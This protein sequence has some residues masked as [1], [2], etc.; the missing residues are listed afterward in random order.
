MKKE[1]IVLKKVVK[2]KKQSSKKDVIERIPLP[3]K[4]EGRASQKE[5]R[6][7]LVKRIKDVAIYKKEFKENSS[8]VYFETIKV[9]KH[10]GYSL[11]DGPWIPPAERYPSDR[12]FGTYGYCL[13]SLERAK[14]RMN[15]F[16]NK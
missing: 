13:M 3:E 11:G 14:F 4:F 12:E 6:F 2:S 7:E 16:L 15:E 1:K 9:R 5:F 8:I 10:N